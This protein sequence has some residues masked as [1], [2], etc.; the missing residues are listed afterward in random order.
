MIAL[1]V[2]GIAIWQYVA[3]EFSLWL[4]IVFILIGVGSL[5]GEADHGR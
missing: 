1:A 3:G 4:M 5:I 2:I